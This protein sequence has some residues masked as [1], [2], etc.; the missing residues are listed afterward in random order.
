MKRKTKLVLG[1]VGA[2]ALALTALGG[3]MASANTTTKSAF[4]DRVAEL[5]GIDKQKL[6][7]S[8][9]TAT[10]EQ[11]D[12]KVKDGEI[13]QELADK[14]KKNVEEGKLKGFGGMGKMMGRGMGPNHDDIAG[15]L[16]MEA[17]VLRDLLHDG[18]TLTEVAADNG[19]SVDEL[20]SFLSTRFDE[21]ISEA[22]KDGKITQSQADKMTADKAEIIDS[23][24]NGKGPR[25]HR[26]KMEPMQER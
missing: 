5:A 22:L 15:F 2:F 26:L 7:D 19:K 20:K 14:M 16:G 24:L 4:M 25:G 23:L 18:K 12:Q 9:K 10:V 21:R 17:S 1:S 13:T 3:T 8:I 11:I 6:T